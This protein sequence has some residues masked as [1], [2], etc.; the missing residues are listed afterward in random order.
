[1]NASIMTFKPQA[2]LKLE[3]II[4]K[5]KEL[6][7]T[8]VFTNEKPK[9]SFSK[10]EN[11]DFEYDT[12]NRVSIQNNTKEGGGLVVV[13]WDNYYGDMEKGFDFYEEVYDF[14][15]D[16]IV[17]TEDVVID[18][19]KGR[20]KILAVL[21]EDVYQTFVPNGKFLFIITYSYGE[22]DIDKE[23]VDKLIASFKIENATEGEDVDTRQL[24][25]CRDSGT[26]LVLKKPSGWI[27]LRQNTGNEPFLGKK[28]NSRVEFIL[29][30]RKLAERE[31]NMSNRDYLDYISEDEMVKEETERATGFKAERYYSSAD[32][33]INDELTSEIFYKY[34][35]K[36]EE[37]NSRFFSAV[38]R[39]G[40]PG[41]ISI[42]EFSYMG[43]D[44]AEFE[45]ELKSFQNEIMATATFESYKNER[46]E[47]QEN[48]NSGSVKETETITDNTKTVKS[49]AAYNRVRGKILLKVEDSGKAYYVNPKNNTVNYLGRPEDAFGVMRD[50]GVGITNKDLYKIPVGTTSEDGIDSDGDGLSDYLEDTLGLNSKAA[51]TDNDGYMDGPELAAGYNPWGAGKQELDNSFTDAQKGR[52]LLQVEKNGEAWYVN[53][54]DG[55]RYFLGR[56][57]DAYSAMRNLGLGI[58][59]NDF[60]EL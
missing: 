58:S 13:N 34:K 29:H 48:K 35:F 36:D 32:Y 37:G 21:G 42:I 1:M 11:W 27:Y 40:Y 28:T 50:Q 41:N 44:E 33:K 6:K 38:Y 46:K 4:K 47:W 59:N 10:S 3:T 54:A 22:D 7:S 5:Q 45:A 15:N 60:N 16:L 53:P 39:I 14:V 52:I 20:K 56:P 43:N 8:N 55:K 31:S 30:S 25:E 26:N 12:Q 19:K 17:Y 49:S 57:R 2:D 23:E 51:D 24:E 9:F 18:N